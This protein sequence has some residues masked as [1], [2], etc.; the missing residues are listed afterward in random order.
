[1]RNT[2]WTKCTFFILCIIH[3]SQKRWG[4]KQFQD[5]IISSMILIATRKS[6]EEFYPNSVPLC[7]AF[8]LSDFSS[9]FTVTSLR[10]NVGLSSQTPTCSVGPDTPLDPF[11]DFT[12]YLFSHPVCLSLPHAQGSIRQCFY[13]GGTGKLMTHQSNLAHCMFL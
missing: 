13:E 10:S 8:L 2:D 4:W 1:M 5:T 12:V 9:I 11:S 6:C 7:R 3:Y